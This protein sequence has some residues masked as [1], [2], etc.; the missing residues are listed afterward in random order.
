MERKYLEELGLEKN[1]IDKVMDA[2]SADIGKHKKQIDDLAV[3]RDTLNAQ[4]KDVKGKLA[5]F[6][7]VNVDEL[8]KEISS[9][10]TNLEEKEKDF[11]N[12]LAE[13][14][15]N[16]M[17]TAAITSAKGRNVKAITSLL[18][19]DTLKSSKNQKEDIAQAIA[20]LKKTDA[21]QFE[22]EESPVK[23]KT[24]GEHTEPST[25]EDE[26]F[27]SAAMQGAGLK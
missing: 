15:F 13:R 11:K 4:L 5:A 18:D 20:E 2:H 25:T 9:L 10:K 3:E 21:Y 1:I 27:I 7:D 22:D 8:K 24:G 16:E 12:Q 6:D 17:L 19:I 23:V 26:K 14:D